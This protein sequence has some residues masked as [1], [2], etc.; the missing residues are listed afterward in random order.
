MANVMGLTRPQARPPAQS[1]RKTPPRTAARAWWGGGGSLVETRSQRR[2]RR[3]LARA[4]SSGSTVLPLPSTPSLIP[5]RP[6]DCL[7]SPLPVCLITW[8]P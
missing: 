2:P 8:L 3:H 6:S 5:N 7:Q 4:W 1:S